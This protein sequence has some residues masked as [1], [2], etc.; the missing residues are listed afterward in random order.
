MIQIIGYGHYCRKFD[1]PNINKKR[2]RNSFII[3][4]SLIIIII[5]IIRRRIIIILLISIV[6]LSISIF[7]CTVQYDLNTNI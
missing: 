6:Q 7:D 2:A 1:I 4:S 3:K 5:I